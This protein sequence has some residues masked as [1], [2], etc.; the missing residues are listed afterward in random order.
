MEITNEQF[1]TTAQIA[2]IIGC[3]RSFI[4]K[5]LEIGELDYFRF[6]GAIRVKASDVEAYINRQKK[7]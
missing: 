1:L 3:S 7:N 2:K 4:Y 5:I 6:G